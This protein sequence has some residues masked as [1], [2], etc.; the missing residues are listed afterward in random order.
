M[1]LGSETGSVM[2]HLYSRMTR[3]A[4]SPTLGLGVTILH[5]SDRTPGTIVRIY[6]SPKGIVIGIADD[7]YRLNPG[8][9]W[10]SETIDYEI[11]PCA[12]SC[13]PRRFYRAKP[14]GGWEPVEAGK[15]Y[16]TWKKVGGAGL[17][18][19]RRERYYDPSF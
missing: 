19:G 18:V 4:P 10:P 8:A 13:E 5:W 1:K 7:H 16:G 15:R 11:T 12:L 9:A 14:D 17:L 3:N 6:S 2:N